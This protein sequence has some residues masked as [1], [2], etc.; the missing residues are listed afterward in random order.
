MNTSNQCFN[1]YQQPMVLCFTIKN[2]FINS[3]LSSKLLLLFY[4]NL[5]IYFSF[6]IL[7]N[8]D[9]L[10][11][12]S[13]YCLIFLL[14]SSSL[15]SW[16]NWQMTFLLEIRKQEN[17]CD[18]KKKIINCRSRE[19]RELWKRDKTKN[20]NFCLRIIKKEPKLYSRFSC[21]SKLQK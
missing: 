4:E 17:I 10:R 6:L 15:K 19:K 9:I 20:Q 11:W 8:L 3:F 21:V 18:K 16:W 12:E 1:F 13:Y 2:K 14:L 5:Y 7:E